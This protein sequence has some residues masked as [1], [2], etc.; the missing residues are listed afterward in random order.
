L[1][2]ISRQG[3]FKRIK[4]AL[5]RVEQVAGYRSPEFNQR[6]RQ[7]LS[8]YVSGVATEEER[9]RAERL[10]ASDPYA[11]AVARELRR[12]HETAALLLPVFGVGA[13]E[14]VGGEGPIASAIARVSEAVSGLVGRSPAPAEIAKSS[15]ITSG[16]GRG[17]GVAGAG[18]LAKAFGGLSASEVALG[19]LGSGAVATVACV[20][21]GI[22][23]FPGGSDREPSAEAQ[24]ERAARPQ[25]RT[26]RPVR[27][28]Q[29]SPA[30]VSQE[31]N[32]AD[33]DRG[34]GV[35]NAQGSGGAPAPAAASTLEPDTPPEV[36][37]FGVA[38]AGT[39]VGGASPDTDDANGAS[40]ST[41][42]Q[43]FGP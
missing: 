10:I 35:S 34:G 27:L 12:T 5:A 13:G 38:G 11:L 30:P 23:P 36:Q 40:A 7:L 9:A 8:D 18:L 17:A 3:Y 28:L 43:E 39:P 37:E 19:C 6:Q 2:G 31:V 15:V 25:E 29:R 20:A 42:R 1:L 22:L 41:V 21:T 33:S 16:A 14:A 26:P 4:T 24:I 32:E